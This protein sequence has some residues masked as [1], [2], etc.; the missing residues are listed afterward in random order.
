M[1]LRIKEVCKQK[2]VTITQ[3]AE[4]KL[5]IKQESLSRAI[6]GNP[7]KDTLEKIAAALNVPIT[8]LFETPENDVIH[9]PHCGG[10]IK[11][12]KN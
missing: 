5:K 9:C 8:E 1:N 12:S 11:V 6:N 3:L 10:R 2:G 4:E 7:T